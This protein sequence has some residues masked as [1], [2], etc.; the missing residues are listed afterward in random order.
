MLLFLSVT[1][2][3]STELYFSVLDLFHSLDDQFN[4]SSGKELSIFVF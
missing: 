2:K 4:L 3:K 1:E